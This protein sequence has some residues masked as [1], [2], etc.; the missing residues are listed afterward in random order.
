MDTTLILLGVGCIIGGIIGGGVKFVQIELSQV[1]SL[2]RQSLLAIF[3]VILVIIGLGLGGN[4]PFGGKPAAAPPP[5]DTV[6]PKP[7]EPEPQPKPD[8]QTA[9]P[10]ETP[11]PAHSS[12]QPASPQQ[13]P[14]ATPY[15]VDIFACETADGGDENQAIA[16]PILTALSANPLVSR[17]RSRTLSLQTNAQSSYGITANIVRYDP[18]EQEM[19]ATIAQIATQASGVQFRPAHALPGSPSINY[20]SVFVCAAH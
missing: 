15:K 20:L 13:P 10:T 18:G 19:A 6:K 2:W 3:G 16:A 12:E 11:K 9:P 8:T 7:V 4:L 17:A 14:A 1:Q 5:A